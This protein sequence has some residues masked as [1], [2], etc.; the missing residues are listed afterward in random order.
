MTKG[1]F[2]NETE[3]LLQGISLDNF[4]EEK[5]FG[6]D[7]PTVREL[8]GQVFEKEGHDSAIKCLEQ[9]L[10]HEGFWDV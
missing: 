4:L 2:F 10:T 9:V 8:L 3:A 1:E 7:L 6:E 5:L